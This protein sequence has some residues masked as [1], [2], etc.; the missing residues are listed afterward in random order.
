M[1]PLTVLLKEPKNGILE[2]NLTSGHLLLHKS[3]TDALPVSDEGS[4]EE[5]LMDSLEGAASPGDIIPLLLASHQ[6][7]HHLPPYHPDYMPASYNPGNQKRFTLPAIFGL[8]ARPVRS[9][10]QRRFGS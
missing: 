10:R 6:F 4:L 9:D 1:G 3:A 2:S 5:T 8:P 7:N